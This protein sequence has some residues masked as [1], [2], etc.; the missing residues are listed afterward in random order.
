MSSPPSSS[1]SKSSL[2]ASTGF[3]DF[4]RP[5]LFAVL[6]AALGLA[7]FDLGVLTGA[8]SAC[9]AESSSAG[10][11][12]F[13]V[14]TLRALTAFFPSAAADASAAGRV[15]SEGSVFF[16]ARVFRTGLAFSSPAGYS[17]VFKSSASALATTFLADLRRRVG[18]TGSAAAAGLSSGTA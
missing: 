8:A 6:L 17:G 16:A 13:T 11:L 7:A 10:A 12:A 1:K 4:L 5:L 9:S 2:S 15:S 14:L 18:L 3:A